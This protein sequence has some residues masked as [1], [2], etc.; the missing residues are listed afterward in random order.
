MTQAIVE[1][2]VEVTSNISDMLE[3]EEETCQHLD[4]I[5]QLELYGFLLPFGF[6]S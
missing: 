3:G 4:D 6:Q 5:L 1:R 2:A